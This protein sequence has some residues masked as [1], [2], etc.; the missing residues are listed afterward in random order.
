VNPAVRDHVLDG[1]RRRNSATLAAIARRSAVVTVSKKLLPLAAVALLIALGLAPSWHSGPDKER[2]TYHMG[3]TNTKDDSSRM[4]GARYH[5]VDQQGQ[6]FT[7]TAGNAIQQGPDNVALTRP[8]GD[9]TMKSGSWLELRS[10]TGMFN[11]KS[12]IL[13]LAGNVTLYRNDGTTVTTSKAAINLQSGNA[14][15]T[16]PTDVQG[17][18]GTLH[19]DHGFVLA[20]RG[21]EITFNGPAT[22]TLTQVK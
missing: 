6:P 12:Q 18:F 16:A 9:I 11:Q 3:K 5:G 2:V 8:V 22:L 4:Q 1:L 14:H 19:A 10:N 7:V 21:A 15:G 13:G 20:N 17:P